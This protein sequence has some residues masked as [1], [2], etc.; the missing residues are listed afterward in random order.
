MCAEFGARVPR[1]SSGRVT[2]S[3][4]VDLVVLDAQVGDLLFAHEPAEGVLELGLLDDRAIAMSL[5]SLAAFARPSRTN[6]VARTLPP[7]T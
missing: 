4:F 7:S 5:E 2:S 1:L 3:G 6:Q